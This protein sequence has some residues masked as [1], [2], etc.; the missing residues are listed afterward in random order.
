MAWGT[1]S[2]LGSGSRIPKARL[3][4]PGIPRCDGA[5]R[6]L[7]THRLVPADGH[8]GARLAAGAGEGEV[9]WF[10]PVFPVAAPLGE[11][12]REAR[13][14]PVLGGRDG[15]VCCVCLWVHCML[16]WVCTRVC[17]PCVHGCVHMCICVC[18]RGWC[19]SPPRA[20]PQPMWGLCRCRR[21]QTKAGAALARRGR[22]GS[23]GSTWGSGVHTQAVGMG[24][25]LPASSPPCWCLRLQTRSPGSPFSPWK[26]SREVLSVPRLRGS[27]GTP[28]PPAQR[29]ASLHRVTPAMELFSLGAGTGEWPQAA[30]SLC[31]RCY[32]PR[33]RHPLPR[34][35][36]GPGGPVDPR[37]PAWR[38]SHWKE[39]MC[40]GEHRGCPPPP[41]TCSPRTPYSPCSPPAAPAAPWDQACP[42]SPSLRSGQGSLACPAVRVRPSH[43][44]GTRHVG[45]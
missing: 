36:L 6:A 3:G 9:A 23:R 11:P 33:L 37:C 8:P 2:R 24:T 5:P 31:P 41:S 40:W 19:D 30:L 32:H 18:C 14:E 21:G 44:T 29:C 43:P 4:S 15:C 17:A 45:W 10:A 26:E 38:E 7:R 35:T 42:G 1:Q 16:A 22:G 39:R 34:L 20:V 27:L 28:G 13:L 25:P 12:Q